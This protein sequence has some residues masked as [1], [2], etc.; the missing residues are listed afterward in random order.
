MNSGTLRLVDELIDHLI[1]EFMD[2]SKTTLPLRRLGAPW[3]KHPKLLKPLE[4]FQK[5]MFGAGVGVGMLRG[6]GDFL[7]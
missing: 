2:S 5:R 3:A 7:T 6:A 4:I 1:D